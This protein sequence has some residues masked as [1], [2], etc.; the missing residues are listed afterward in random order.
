MFPALRHVS[1]ASSFDFLFHVQAEL[2]LKDEPVT[3]TLKGSLMRTTLEGLGAPL[4]DGVSWDFLAE[5]EAGPR[6][7]GRPWDTAPSHP[8]AHRLSLR[9]LLHW[10]NSGPKSAMLTIK[11]WNTT[12]GSKVGTCRTRRRR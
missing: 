5:G 6:R 12:S 4:D 8:S 9:P 7:E 11:K 1:L 3:A 2:T 10:Q